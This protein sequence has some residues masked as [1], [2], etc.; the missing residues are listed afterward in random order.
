MSETQFLGY[1]VIALATLTG[2]FVVV[3]KPIMNAVRALTELNASIA[4]LQDDV[5]AIQDNI[6]KQAEHDREGRRKLWQAHGDL[7]SRVDD[8]DKRIHTLEI[9]GPISHG[10]MR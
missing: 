7:E 3:G 5:A 10:D 1:L 2:L 4:A 6:Q 9:Q 8:H